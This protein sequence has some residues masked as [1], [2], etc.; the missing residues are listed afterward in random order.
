MKY[1]AGAWR[2]KM[3]VRSMSRGRPTPHGLR[4]VGEG[5]DAVVVGFAGDEAG[6]AGDTLDGW[7]VWVQRLRFV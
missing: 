2:I 4:V 5:V 1:T 7:V 6:D 3:N